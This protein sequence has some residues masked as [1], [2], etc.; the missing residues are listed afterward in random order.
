MS[1]T[2]GG[3]MTR[4]IKSR[5]AVLPSGFTA[6]ELLARR[7]AEMPQGDAWKGVDDLNPKAPA[8]HDYGIRTS[9]RLTRQY[10]Q[11]HRKQATDISP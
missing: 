11:S 4:G 1:R 3:P 10:R 6:A 8:G 2:T 9:T 5:P 7:Q